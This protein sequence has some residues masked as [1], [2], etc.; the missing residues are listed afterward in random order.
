M[1]AEQ[2]YK[3][4]ICDRYF[5]SITN[6]HLKRH[7]I[8]TAEYKIKFPDAKFGNFDRFDNWR[9]SDENKLNCSNMN[10][11]V[12]ND[13]DLNQKRIEAV[14][15]VTK[16]SEYKL[17]QSKK[18]KEISKSNH[19]QNFY[20]SAKSRVTDWMKKSNFERWEILFGKE[21]AERRLQEWSEKN[22]MPSSSRNTKPEK[23]FQSILEKFNI[24]F[25][26]Q[27]RVGKYICDF[28]IPDYNLI[29]EIDGDY[30]H[31]N[32]IRFNDSDIIGPKNN[33]V[34]DIW[35][36][37]LKKSNFIISKGYNLIRYWES[38]IKNISH[39]KI[40]ED[41]VQTSKKLDDDKVAIPFHASVRIKLGAGSPIEGPDKEPIGINVSAK[42]I[43]NKVSAPFRKAEF[44]IIFG[45]GIVEH[46]EIFDNLRKL[47]EFEY[48]GKRVSI[49]GG[50]AWKSLLV[51][52][53]SGVVE[54]EKKFYK[55][56]FDQIMRD[57]QYKE[58][59]D[60]A[61]DRAYTKQASEIPIEDIDPDSYIENEAVAM[62]LVENEY[63]A[64]DY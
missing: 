5:K 25:S 6:S 32:P 31:A 57:P 15:K 37:D 55:S 58:Y 9:K 46:E 20:K 18:M 36:K 34:K 63:L 17:N 40:F 22:I 39:E 8:T 38:D 26:N 30:W 7:N 51:C 44:R 21:E 49:D 50:G 4:E 29:V 2:K 64:G 60:A 42:I 62:A 48:N 1:S 19:M 27:K 3:C 10:K 41:I 52:T 47:G 23:I 28:Y 45:K 54:L 43:K 61:I 56:E 13:P 12:Y 59:V 33:L 14:K 11:K 35:E 16:S 24:S 53:M